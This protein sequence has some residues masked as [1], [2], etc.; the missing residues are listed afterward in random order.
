MKYYMNDVLNLR[1]VMEHLPL[2]R[3]ELD[4]AI[5]EL[6]IEILNDAASMMKHKVVKRFQ[7]WRCNPPKSR[8]VEVGTIIGVHTV[9]A[10]N[11][12]GHFFIINEDNGSWETAKQDL[13]DNI[14]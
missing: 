11:G 14:Q 8:W 9:D 7:A 13:L 3:E 6:M 10:P 2:A 5:K 1:F 4:K 12:N